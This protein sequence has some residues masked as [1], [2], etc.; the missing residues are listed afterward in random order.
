MLPRLLSTA[1]TLLI[2]RKADCDHLCDMELK[3]FLV[4]PMIPL[5]FLERG[6][7][8]ELCDAKRRNFRSHDLEELAIKLL[9]RPLGLYFG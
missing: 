7:N 2:L 5:T 9:P 1:R 4:Y 3:W 8:T 6:T